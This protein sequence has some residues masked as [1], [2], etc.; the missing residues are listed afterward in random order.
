MIYLSARTRHDTVDPRPE[1]RQAMRLL[2]AI[3]AQLQLSPDVL[4]QHIPQSLY[5][6]YEF[7]ARTAE[8]SGAFRLLSVVG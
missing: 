2:Q 5:T 1:A 8:T 6:Q 4:E 7:L 3:M